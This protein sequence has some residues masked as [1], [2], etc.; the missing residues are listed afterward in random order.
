MADAASALLEKFDLR[1][2]EV[3]LMQTAT[4]AI[5]SGSTIS[6]FFIPFDPNDIDI[7]TGKGVGFCVV[8]YFEKGGRYSV[9]KTSASYD[10]AAGIGKVWELRHVSSGKKINVIE[11][12]SDNPLHSV[13]HFH[14]TCVYSTWDARKYWHGYPRLAMDGQAIT[15]L[16]RFPLKEEL[17]NHMHAWEVLRKYKLRGFRFSF[18]EHLAPHTCGVDTD[19]PA[20]PRTSDD[21]GCLSIPWPSWEFDCEAKESKISVWTLGG[22]GCSSGIMSRA[23]LEST[24]YAMETVRELRLN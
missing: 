6:A 2:T 10:F 5:I 4:G 15:N 12:L 14:L 8:R 21:N 16:S 9:T 19:C 18:D 23:G 11:S 17:K 13:L 24:E 1:L 3:R 7:Y 22:S 20:T